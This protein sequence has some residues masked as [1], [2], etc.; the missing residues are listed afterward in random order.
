MSLSKSSN[1]SVALGMALKMLLLDQF[2]NKAMIKRVLFK[3]GTL[4]ITGQL[5]EVNL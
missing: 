4:I 3:F 5:C 2:D 1:I